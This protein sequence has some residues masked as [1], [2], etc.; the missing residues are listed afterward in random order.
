MRTPATASPAIECAKRLRTLI[1]QESGPSEELDCKAGIHIIAQ[2]KQ[3]VAKLEPMDSSDKMDAPLTATPIKM[4]VENSGDEVEVIQS[5]SDK[6]PQ[7]VITTQFDSDEDCKLDVVASLANFT[8][9]NEAAPSAPTTETA[10]SRT[11]TPPGQS[12]LL[13]AWTREED[14]VILIEM[15]MGARDRQHLIK[16]MGAKLQHRNETELRGRHQFL[17]DFLS[18]LQGK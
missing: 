18:K 1:D 9:R 12:N 3:T 5:S 2:A 15:K 7:H 8:D 6:T 10:S 16:R 17:M 14:K 4:D 13:G 11:A